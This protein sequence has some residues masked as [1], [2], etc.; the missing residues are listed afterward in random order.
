MAFEE[1]PD[2]GD[3]A[4]KNGFLNKKYG[5]NI[6]DHCNLWHHVEIKLP[7]SDN[8]SAKV[9]V[10][11]DKAIFDFTK[12][13]FSTA[14]N[15]PVFPL[16]AVNASTSTTNKIRIYLGFVGGF[17]ADAGM[18]SPSDSPPYLKTVTATPGSY[19]F[20]AHLT[21]GYNSSVGIWSV[22]AST[23]A[24]GA[25]VPSSDSTNAYVLLA[26]FTVGA[27]GKITGISPMVTG[28]QAYERIGNATTYTEKNWKQ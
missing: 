22:S 10:S 20:Y 14:A 25:S 1:V 18:T 12:T 23:I 11:E 21:V 13:K 3:N 27:S 8:G 16:K 17:I 26:N 19:V 4:F 2:P 5:E 24:V 15:D 28:S 7:T 9:L 6:V